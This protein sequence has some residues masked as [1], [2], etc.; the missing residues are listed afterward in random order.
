[1]AAAKVSQWRV[2][3]S[4][5][6]PGPDVMDPKIHHANLI[7]SILAKLEANAAG[8]DDALVLDGTGFVA[9]TTATHVF[10]VTHEGLA[11]PRTVACPEG[12]TRA[13]VLE[14][15]RELGIE[16]EERD[17]S[18][19]ELYRADECFCT[20]TMGELAGIVAIDGRRIGTRG[21]DAGPITRRLAERYGELA[22]SGGEPIVD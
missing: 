1:M 18:Q 5:R 8:A 11:T 7:P 17:L 10:L 15:C 6:R 21:D 16:A 3:A 14:L 13:T 22:A 19:M 4:V 20:G 9:E 2:P 12:V